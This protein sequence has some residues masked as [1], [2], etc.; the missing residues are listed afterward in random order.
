ME[1][2][3][4][5]RS[6]AH[7]GILL[8]NL[9]IIL[10][11]CIAIPLNQLPPSFW[12]SLNSDLLTK[13]TYCTAGSKTSTKMHASFNCPT[14]FLSGPVVNLDPTNLAHDCLQHFICITHPDSKSPNTC[15]LRSCFSCIT[16]SNKT[17]TWATFFMFSKYVNTLVITFQVRSLVPKRPVCDIY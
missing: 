13:A 10:K 5:Q 4:Q 14:W 7:L 11:L 12:I 16:R 2:W 8:E 6:S 9:L 17:A 3:D 15:L 1:L